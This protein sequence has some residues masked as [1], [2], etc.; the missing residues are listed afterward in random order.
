[1]PIF[2]QQIADPQTS[3]LASYRKC[4]FASGCPKSRFIGHIGE[5][6]RFP[7][8]VVQR[9]PRIIGMRSPDLSRSSPGTKMSTEGARLYQ[10]APLVLALNPRLS[11]SFPK[12]GGTPE[13]DTHA[14]NYGDHFGHSTCYDKVSAPSNKIEF[15]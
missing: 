6:E 15:P 9:P 2:G 12:S 4:N 13:D 8:I 7:G 1:M 14:Q 10:H 5:V 11:V 3:A